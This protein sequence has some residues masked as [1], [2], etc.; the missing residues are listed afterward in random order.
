[1]H[2]V[3]TEPPALRDIAHHYRYLVANARSEGYAERWFAAV[4]SAI[5]DLAE[6]PARHPIAPEDAEFEEEIRHCL[7]DAYRILFTIVGTRVHVLHVRHGRQDVLR[8]VR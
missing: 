2:E 1:V 5:D 7:L 4:E 3:V 6:R 8:P